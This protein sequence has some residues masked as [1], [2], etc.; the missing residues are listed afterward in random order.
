ME[1]ELLDKN[2]YTYNIEIVKMDGK[3]AF[4]KSLEIKNI[5]PNGLLLYLIE[6]NV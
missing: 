6:F 4:G 1:K 2:N 5:S 3:M